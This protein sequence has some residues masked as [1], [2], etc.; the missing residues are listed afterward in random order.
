MQLTKAAPETVRVRTELVVLVG[1]LAAALAL[2]FGPVF[3]PGIVHFSNDG[4]LGVQVAE[5]ARLP[6]G[7]TGAWNDLNSIGINAG[8]FPP[9]FSTLLRL[10]A[11]PVGYA[12]FYAP[13][14]LFLVGLGAW[15]FFRRLGLDTSACILGALAAALN[16]TYFSTA[17]W[18]VAS[19]VI[20]FSMNFFALGLVVSNTSDTPPVLRYVRL[21]LAGLAVGMG[22]LE[23]FDIGAIFSLFTAAFVMF[24]ALNEASSAVGKLVHGVTNVAL[25][26]L[27]AGFIAAQTLVA[28]VTT[29]IKGVVVAR[30][31]ARLTE[32]RFDWAKWDWATQW[33]LP[34]VETLGLFVPGLFGYRMDTPGG[35]E[36]WGR[37]GRDPA[38][39]R[40]YGGGPIVP[41]SVLKVSFP[42]N[43]NMD[44]TVAVDADGKISLPLIGEVDVLGKKL[45]RVEAELTALYAAKLPGQAVKVELMRP[46][47][48]TRYTGGGNYL[49]TVLWLVAAWG[50]A[51]AL[52]GSRSVFPTA[53]RQHILFWAIAALVAL[54][55][56]YGRHAPFYKLFY[57]LPYMSAIRNPTKF[58]HVFTWAMVIVFAYGVHGLSR[59]YLQSGGAVGAVRFGE[60]LKNWWTA[61]KGFDRAWTSGLLVTAAACVGAFLVY[62]SMRPE[63]VAYLAETYRP[64]AAADA[65]LLRSL[66]EIASFSVRQAGLFVLFF[67]AGAA[68][69]IS[70]L[71]GAFAGRRAKLGATLLGLLLVAEL[72]RANT[73]WTVFWD[74]RYKY[75]TNAVIELLRERPYERRV[76]ILPVP[77]PREL[78]LFEQLYRIE[79][80][81]HHFPYYNIQSLDIVQMPRMPEDLAAFETA[82]A[83]TG[84]AETIHLVP[85]R[86]QLTSTRYLLSAAA[87]A[88]ALN[89]WLD[90]ERRQFDI[91]MR[92]DLALKPGV[93]NL[94]KL[95]DLTVVDTPD[96]ALA[97]IEFK[98]AL[99]RAR[100]YSTWQVVTN[101]ETALRLIASREFDPWQTVLV[102]PPVPP[103]MAETG[104]NQN[105][106]TVQFQS[107]SP[108]RIKLTAEAQA[109]SVLL[110]NDKF[111]R[112]WQVYVD[113][114][115]AT[116]AMQFHHAR[117]PGRRAHGRVPLRAVPEAPYVELA[118]IA[119]GVALVGVVVW[120]ESRRVRAG[121]ADISPPPTA[122]TQPRKGSKS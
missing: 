118:A 74:Y 73:Y 32:K 105:L 24:V 99:P 44:T 53:T 117:S 59:C 107:Y 95:E 4:P 1:L 33:S 21:G 26:A 121:K 7:L 46:A 111:D 2:L 14:A 97:V 96:G 43:P 106:G 61:R 114:A 112:G 90:P 30:P 92:F 11:G 23:G 29:Q 34:K 52:R 88:S 55:L 115:R 20:T 100:L 18:G 67:L 19:Q 68:A 116:V 94:A 82:L 66:Q 113:G 12:K 40:Y 15:F 35:G 51:Q 56:A 39:D 48:F 83:Y 45:A 13:F 54:L 78:G 80:A 9:S 89:E 71:S 108:K 101:D 41:G 47:G 85:R 10:V 8:T 3:L 37:V 57:M 119:L 84:G 17:C 16:G 104:T 65:N 98:G 79:W 77:L 27:F 60:R 64:G 38:W 102:C 25:I 49:G 93:T 63:L 122:P 5:W 50:I 62:N 103:G 86:W 31:G 81:Q 42:T 75:A 6:E 70:V 58:L 76:A 72:A 110:L 22:V 36:Y 91:A 120:L 87:Y 69:M 109:P 28:M